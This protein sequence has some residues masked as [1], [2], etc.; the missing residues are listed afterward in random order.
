MK[1]TRQTNWRVV[2]YPTDLGNRYPATQYDCSDIMKQIE[3]HVDGLGHIEIQHTLEISC[4][5]CKR[6]WEES[7][8][9]EGPYC[10]EKAQVGWEKETGKTMEY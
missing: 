9:E 1:V 4:K 8:D 3:R 10:C 5:Y 6:E 2:V 7:Y